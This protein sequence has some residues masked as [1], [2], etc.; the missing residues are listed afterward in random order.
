LA[1]SI[2]FIAA[3]RPI[4]STPVGQAPELF[5]EMFG[6]DAEKFLFPDEDALTDRLDYFVEHPDEFLELAERAKK[7]VEK[8]YSWKSVAEKTLKVYESVTS[9]EKRK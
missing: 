2:F 4:F 3:G 7:K 5:R 8:S 6:S 9:K 1:R